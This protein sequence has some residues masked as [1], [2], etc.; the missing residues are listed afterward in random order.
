MREEFTMTPYYRQKTITL[1]IVEND[2]LDG[3]VRL[4]WPDGSYVK[5]YNDPD[6]DT[7][8]NTLQNELNKEGVGDD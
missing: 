5:V 3:Y 1:T 7:L 2:P 8:F 4:M 6:D